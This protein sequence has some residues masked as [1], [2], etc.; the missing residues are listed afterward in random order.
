MPRPPKISPAGQGLSLLLLLLLICHLSQ[1]MHTTYMWLPRRWDP[2]FVFIQGVTS[3]ARSAWRRGY[4]ACTNMSF[5][6]TRKQRKSL[7]LQHILLHAHG[8]ELNNSK[9][10]LV[11]VNLYK[12]QALYLSLFCSLDIT[13]PDRIKLC[14][15]VRSIH[16]IPQILAMWRYSLLKIIQILLQCNWKV[17]PPIPLYLPIIMVP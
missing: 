4:S 2:Q 8:I 7:A 12:F 6:P 11:H 17:V 13:S 3:L 16:H 14:I 10:N 9:L 15:Y 5:G 1:C